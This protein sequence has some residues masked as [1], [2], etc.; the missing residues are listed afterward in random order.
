MEKQKKV[1]PSGP[2][3]LA[4]VRPVLAVQSVYIWRSCEALVLV[5]FLQSGPQWIGSGYISLTC[6][7]PPCF[8]RSFSGF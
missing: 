7:L 3:S 5:V 2:L 1:V 8:P 6:I 4:G